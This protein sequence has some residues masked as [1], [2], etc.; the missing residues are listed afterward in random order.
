MSITQSLNEL[1]SIN[2]ELKRINAHAKKLRKRKKVLENTISEF[3]DNKKQSG[4]K[5]N[6]NAFTKQT[7]T[8]R[9]LKNKDD[10]KIDAM[11]ILES[12]GIHDPELLYDELFDSR[13]YSESNEVSKLS[14][15]KMK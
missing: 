7:K 8:V 9:K 15:K 14:V 5:Y 3:L 11:R 2:T 13:R 12:H 4:F 1:E 6:G 10:M